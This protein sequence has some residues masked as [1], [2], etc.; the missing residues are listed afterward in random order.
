MRLFAFP[1]AACVA[2]FSF[3]SAADSAPSKA[4]VKAL[5][6]QGAAHIVGLQQDNGSFGPATIKQFVLG[7]SELCTLALLEAGRPTDDPVVKKAI[8]FILTFKQP[9][10]SISD[11]NEGNAN[12]TTAIALMVFAKA[13]MKGDPIVDAAQKAVIS[14]QNTD[15]KSFNVGGIGYGSR[16]KGNEDLSNTAMAIEGLTQSGLSPDHPAMKKALGFV[17][18]CQNLSSFNDQAFAKNAKPEDLG[19]GVYSPDT[20]KAGGTYDDKKAAPNDGPAKTLSSYGS[21][22]YALVK[23]YL[24][25]NLKADDPRV[26]AA[27]E[28][29]KRNYRMD[30]NPGM[31]E[32]KAKEG[33]FYYY[34]MM[35]KTFDILDVTV[36]D[37]P[38]GKKADWRIDLFNAIKE[39]A[40]PSKTQGGVF[41]INEADRW[42]EGMD[43]ITTPYLVTALARIHASM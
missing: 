14:W 21:M 43:T 23:S 22:S 36:L 29:M 28:W 18:R 16:G 17:Q 7:R 9:D 20:S 19:G 32:K 25:L 37:L 2:V 39:R 30:V 31:G 3:A 13:N 26:S 5:M 15:E 12:Y 4:D 11:P 27:L 1:A 40:K 8:S 34:N 10:G 38:D 6:D 35:A 41:W 33:L 24:A 42:A